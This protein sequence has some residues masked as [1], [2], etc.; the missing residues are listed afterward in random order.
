MAY[1]VRTGHASRSFWW[2]RID[3]SRTA[4]MMNPRISPRIR[5]FL[6][7][8]NT[9]ARLRCQPV[10]S[11]PGWWNWQTR[12]TQNPLPSQACGFKS[13]PGYSATTGKV[14]LSGSK[15]EPAVAS[16]AVN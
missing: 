3:H 5:R 6:M 13:R 12:R 16:F 9:F 15:A 1:G 14:A 8:V 7:M 11:L 10:R 4:E 2:R